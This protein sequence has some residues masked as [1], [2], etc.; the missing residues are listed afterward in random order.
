MPTER[1]I[2]QLLHDIQGRLDGDVSLTAIAARAG[3]SPFHFHRAFRRVTGETPKQYTQRLRLERAAA[4]LV[5]GAEAIVAIA[6]DAGFASHEVFTR[7]FRRQF[8]RTP[9]GYRAEALKN[10][11]TQARARHAAVAATAGPCVGLFHIPLD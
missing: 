8:G 6:A 11:G 10:A 9:A 5:T 7:A 1:E 2:L 3:W 4:R